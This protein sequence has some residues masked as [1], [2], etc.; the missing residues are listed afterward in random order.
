[1]KNLLYRRKK[2]SAAA[3]HSKSAGIEEASRPPETF[4]YRINERRLKESAP[5][6]NFFQ[7]K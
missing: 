1:M 3:K 7:C 4:I 5:H 2:R 6:H